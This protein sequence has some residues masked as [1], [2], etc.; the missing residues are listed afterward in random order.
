[1]PSKSYE[2]RVFKGRREADP[3]NK[4]RDV[5]DLTEAERTKAL[6]TGHLLAAAERAGVGRSQAHLFHLDVHEVHGDRADNRPLFAFSVP[7]VA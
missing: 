3:P 7:V 4:L 2:L 1:M 5:L 6:L